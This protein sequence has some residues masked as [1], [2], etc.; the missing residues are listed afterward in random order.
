MKAISTFN[1][2][3]DARHH[4]GDG[5]NVWFAIPNDIWIMPPN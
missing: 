5:K 2:D 3:Y 4:F 1:Y